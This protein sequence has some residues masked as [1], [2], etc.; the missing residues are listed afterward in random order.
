MART[1]FIYGVTVYNK[2]RLSISLS[3][4]SLRK[5]VPSFIGCSTLDYLLDIF[6]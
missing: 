5:L 4:L 3:E 6:V 2:A 1:L